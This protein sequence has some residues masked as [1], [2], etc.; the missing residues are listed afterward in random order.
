MAFLQEGGCTVRPEEYLASLLRTRPPYIPVPRC[1]TLEL[2]VRLEDAG[3]V[4]DMEKTMAAR[5]DEI[6]FRRKEW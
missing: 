4:V 5:A 2:A 6:W 1:L 3:Y